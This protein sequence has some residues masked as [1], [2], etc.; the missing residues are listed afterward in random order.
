M[1]ES[2][3]L[4]SALVAGVL[5]GGLFFVGLWWTVAR[6]VASTQPA[7]WFLGSLLLRTGLVLPG[8]YVVAAGDWRRWLA[9][10]LGFILARLVVTRFTRPA[11]RE[12]G[13]AP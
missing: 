12:A 5:L 6:A 11:A 9:S 2:L 4:A 1:H 13:H 8:F 10:L 3:S 7:W